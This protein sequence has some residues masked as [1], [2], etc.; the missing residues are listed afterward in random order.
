LKLFGGID[1]LVNAAGH[2]SSGT[3]ENTSLEAWDEMM[4]VNVALS[5]Q[6]MQKAL[7]SLIERRGNSRQRVEVL[8][9]ACRFQACWLLRFK[10]SVGPVNTMRVAGTRGER[11]ESQCV[12]PGVVVTEIHKRGGH[13]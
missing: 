3:I 7:P 6:L 5:F 13:E 1:V 11:R 9:T 8:R 4:N 10:G 12:N 2:I